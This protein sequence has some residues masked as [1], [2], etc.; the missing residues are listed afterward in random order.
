MFNNDKD[1]LFIMDNSFGTHS[2]I[3]FQ[4][5]LQVLDNMYACEYVSTTCLERSTSLSKGQTRRSQT[6]IMEC[7]L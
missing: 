7:T 4:H 6:L 2:K 3:N 5:G 1:T